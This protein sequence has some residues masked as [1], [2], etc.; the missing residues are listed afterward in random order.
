MTLIKYS[1]SRTMME[2]E[3]SEKRNYDGTLNLTVNSVEQRKMLKECAMMQP[4]QSKALTCKL[5]IFAG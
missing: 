5:K 2:C 1:S 4:P 3:I